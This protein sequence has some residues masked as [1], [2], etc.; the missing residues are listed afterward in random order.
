M[1]LPLTPEEYQGFL[2]TPF[3]FFQAIDLP[4]G[5]LTLRMGVFDTISNRAGTLEIPLVVG[6]DSARPDSAATTP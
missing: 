3:Q 5:S 4:P 1:R 6:K 2:Q